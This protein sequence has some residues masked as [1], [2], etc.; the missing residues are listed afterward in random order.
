M[1]L[2]PL[3]NASSALRPCHI[4]SSLLVL[5]DQCVWLLVVLQP[6]PDIALAENRCDRGQNGA[7]I[8]WDSFS[9]P[10]SIPQ[11]HLHAV[12]MRNR[13]DLNLNRLLRRP[14]PSLSKPSGP[15]R[16]RRNCRGEGR[17]NRDCLERRPSV[18]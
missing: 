16:T 6:L 7:P 17:R 5:S 18:G 3:H 4:R 2:P 11:Q 12:P 15:S 8:R 9:P 14:G 1:T 10:V 13:L